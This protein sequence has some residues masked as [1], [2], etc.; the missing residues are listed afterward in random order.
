M[1]LELSFC[2][3]VL[4]SSCSCTS[5]K[6]NKMSCCDRLIGSRRR[7]GMC[8]FRCTVHAVMHQSHVLLNHHQV[9]FTLAFFFV[10]LQVLWRNSH[11][12]LHSHL[13]DPHKS[14]PVYHFRPIRRHIYGQ[15]RAVQKLL[16]GV[17]SETGQRV[18]GGKA[19]SGPHV[20]AV[21]TADQSPPNSQLRSKEA[22]LLS[23]E[24]YTALMW[25]GLH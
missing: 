20:D 11:L 16:A 15:V 19:E 14:K 23:R 7:L 5:Y 18:A 25:T 17:Q 3:F 1:I 10:C 2:L 22:E 9:C 6:W 8:W 24:P 21:I 12:R 4:I 13:R